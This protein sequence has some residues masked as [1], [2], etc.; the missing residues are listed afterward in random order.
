MWLQSAEKY[1][2]FVMENLCLNIS[3][4]RKNC[5]IPSEASFFI[6]DSPMVN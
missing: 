4:M 5:V 3:I 2:L 6:T 1:S